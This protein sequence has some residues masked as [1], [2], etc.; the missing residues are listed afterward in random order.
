MFVIG[1][2]MRPESPAKASAQDL[3]YDLYFALTSQSGLWSFDEMAS[4]QRAAKLEPRPP[5]HLL[6]GQ[7]PGM[8]IGIRS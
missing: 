2:L 1:D 4:W 5:M 6:M 3:F 8:Q 7:G